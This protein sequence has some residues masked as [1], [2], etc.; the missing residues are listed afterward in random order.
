MH[1]SDNNETY[2]S[3]LR[4]ATR[5]GIQLVV[6]GIVFV[7]HGILPFIPVPAS[8]NLAATLQK[9]NEWN[10]HTIQRMQK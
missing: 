2:V 5:I 8:L 6:R 3:H 7:I 1:W 9:V 4:F 10:D